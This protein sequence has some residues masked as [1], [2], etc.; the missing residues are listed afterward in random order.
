LF[1]L[2]FLLFGSLLTGIIKGSI[3]IGSGIVPVSILAIFLPPDQ[4]VVS[5]YPAMLA[6]TL[7][8][9]VPYWKKWD[10]RSLKI[11]GPL[12][13]AGTL[14]GV[15]ILIY[16]TPEILRVLVGTI[17]ILFVLNEFYKERKQ[18]ESDNVKYYKT[19]ASASG[20]VGGI[21]SSMI[22][23]GGVIFSM[24]LLRLKLSKETFVATLIVLM[25]VNDIC[26]GILYGSA[27]LI[28]ISMLSL[29]LIGLFSLIGVGLGVYLCRFISLKYFKWL[30]RGVLLFSGLMLFVTGIKN[31]FFV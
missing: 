7:F 29:F 19:L 25:A 26:K 3:G 22:H 17:A 14:I 18:E 8:S 10:V 20:F 23:S 21:M 15:A 24:L 27:N 6:T 11:M 16:S 28:S 13:I 30:I 1:E 2:I 12:S 5:L 9:L 4:T 31:M